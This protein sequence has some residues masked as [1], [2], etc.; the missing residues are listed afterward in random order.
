MKNGWRTRTSCFTPRSNHAMQFAWT[1]GPQQ[2]RNMLFKYSTNACDQFVEG[3]HWSLLSFCYTYLFIYYKCTHSRSGRKVYA[4]GDHLR[5]LEENTSEKW[6]LIILREGS[7]YI[8]LWHCLWYWFWTHI[9]VVVLLSLL[10]ATPL[11]S[12]AMTSLVN[13]WLTTTWSSRCTP[14]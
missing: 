11:I 2:T 6:K 12:W 5:E 10:R 7:L 4:E 13:S 1:R 3:D 9:V 14:T 8:I